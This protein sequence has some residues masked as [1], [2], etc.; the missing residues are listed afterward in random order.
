M[1][2][3]NFYYSLSSADFVYIPKLIDYMDT[4]DPL[5]KSMPRRY[6]NL[7]RCVHPLLALGGGKYYFTSKLAERGIVE[8]VSRGTT[9]V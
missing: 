4:I 1:P 8:V 5:L 7:A 6:L 3:L 9:Y 2:F